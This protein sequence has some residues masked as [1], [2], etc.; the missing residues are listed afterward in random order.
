MITWGNYNHGIVVDDIWPD[1]SWNMRTS[2][3]RSWVEWVIKM[4]FTVIIRISK[5]KGMNSWVDMLYS[6]LDQWQGSISVSTPNLE[7][8]WDLIRQSGCLNTQLDRPVPNQTLALNIT[9]S[10]VNYES[11]IMILH[12]FHHIQLPKYAIIP[13]IVCLKNNRLLMK[14]HLHE[15]D[16]NRTV[17][18]MV[19]V[20]YIGILN[21]IIH[22]TN[23]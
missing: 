19:C 10:V 12:K 11:M 5:E 3:V 16:V 9:P 18:E 1:S 7:G 6:C 20:K 15:M 23:A 13:L 2:H 8:S 21:I 17:G 4:E 14:P 22:I